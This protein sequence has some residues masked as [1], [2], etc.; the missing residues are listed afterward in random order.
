MT[1]QKK[2]F[3]LLIVGALLVSALGCGKDEKE[4]TKEQAEQEQS[5]EQSVQTQPERTSPGLVKYKI[6]RRWPMGMEVSIPHDATEQQI[7]TLNSNLR[8][9]GNR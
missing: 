4:G 3:A 5:G 1:G 6:E 2:L 9:R 7:K 8:Q